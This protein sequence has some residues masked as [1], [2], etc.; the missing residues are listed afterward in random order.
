MIV[1]ML[2]EEREIARTLDAIAAAAPGAEM[3]VEVIVVDGGSSDRSATRRVRDARC[4]W[5]HRAASPAR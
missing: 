5:S 1:P 4:C 2:N 3:I